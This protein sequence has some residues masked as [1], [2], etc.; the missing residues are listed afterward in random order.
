MQEKEITEDRWEKRETNR[1]IRMMEEFGVSKQVEAG[2]AQRITGRKARSR[3]RGEN[4]CHN[5]GR[6]TA[7]DRGKEGQ[8]IVQQENH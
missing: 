5:I 7:N 6:S 2:L 3:N 4:N 1:K 8:R